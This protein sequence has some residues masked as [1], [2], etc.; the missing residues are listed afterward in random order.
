V[1]HIFAIA[2]ELVKSAGY[3]FDILL[4]L[5]TETVNKLNELSPYE[6]Q[7][8]PAVRNDQNIIRQHLLLLENKPEFSEIYRV[9]SESIYRMHKKDIQTR[10]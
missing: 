3:S 4:P 6:A 2:D 7:T 9:L 8:G 1:N 5:I 10:E